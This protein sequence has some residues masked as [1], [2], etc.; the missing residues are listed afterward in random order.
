MKKYSDTAFVQLSTRLRASLG[1]LS[2][3]DRLQKAIDGASSA[4]ALAAAMRSVMMQDV[5]V[6]EGAGLDEMCDAYIGYAVA[7]VRKNSPEPGMYDSLL[8]KFDAA[9]LKLALKSALRGLDAPK[10]F[11]YGTVD[12][13]T[14]HRCAQERDF[15]ALPKGLAEGCEKAVTAW[16]ESRDAMS[17][18]LLIDRGCFEDAARRAKESGIPLLVELCSLD[19]DAANV[20]AFARIALLDLAA[21]A[22]RELFS[23]AFVCGG[24]LAEVK[25]PRSEMT[26]EALAD[27]VGG[28]YLGA[29][30]RRAAESQDRTATLEGAFRRRRSALCAGV[31]FIPFG[32]EVPAAFIVEREAEARAFALAAAYLRRGASAADIR[33]ALMA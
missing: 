7:T 16:S 11:P 30:V 32:G 23:R 25:F 24:K 8:Y 19:A 5:S 10:L 2:H 27:A 14:V 26:F 15:S 1:T 33:S 17:F 21:E 20:T 4:S 13:K 28:T 22:K 9:N 6:P 12:E 3:T 18:D 31:K 29:D